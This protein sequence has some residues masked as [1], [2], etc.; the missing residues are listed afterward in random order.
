MERQIQNHTDAKNT[1]EK[2]FVKTKGYD[3]L[4]QITEEAAGK[5][6]CC[7]TEISTS[8]L[9]HRAN[10]SAANK[11]NWS[12]KIKVTLAKYGKE[13]D[14]SKNL[15]A[16]HFRKVILIINMQTFPYSRSICEKVDGIKA[17]T[18]ASRTTKGGEGEQT[19]NTPVLNLQNCFM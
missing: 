11:T 5:I 4:S 14:G 17:I 8:N 3:T 13:K 12:R 18:Q 10:P 15:I 2:L 19:R 9:C 1:T 7:A 6:D 16:R